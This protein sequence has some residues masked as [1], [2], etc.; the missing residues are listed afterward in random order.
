MESEIQNRNKKWGDKDR[1]SFQ[2]YI[3]IRK[4]IIKTCAPDI[5]NE[6]LQQ[7]A[8]STRGLIKEDIEK[9]VEE[10]KSK[11]SITYSVPNLYNTCDPNNGN[12]K[13]HLMEFDW[14]TKMIKNEGFS[15]QFLAGYYNLAGSYYKI[16]VKKLLNFLIRIL[17][18]KAMLIAPYYI[19]RTGYMNR[20]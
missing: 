19:I 20:K 7:L 11:G 2:A 16:R 4:D 12:W 6:E 14:L 10:Y 9:C 5:P 13:E 3:D 8:V 1:D 15:V 18:R 17:G